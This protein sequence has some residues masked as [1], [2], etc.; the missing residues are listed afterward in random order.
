MKTGNMLRRYKCECNEIPH[1][2]KFTEQ[3]GKID[4]FSTT[5]DITFSQ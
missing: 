2:K 3:W 5:D 4:M 1:L